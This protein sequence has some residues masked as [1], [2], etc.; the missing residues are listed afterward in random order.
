MIEFLR[1][2]LIKIN[3]YKINQNYAFKFCF[4]RPQTAYELVKC[5]NTTDKFLKNPLNISIYKVPNVKF[6]YTNVS[7]T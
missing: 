7:K 2:D 1:R 5:Y 6:F 3:K 4:K